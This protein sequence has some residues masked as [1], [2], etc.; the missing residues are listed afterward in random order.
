MV[1]TNS[2]IL[3]EESRIRQKAK[4]SNSFIREIIDEFID[5]E[6][7]NLIGLLSFEKERLN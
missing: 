6:I 4:T 1:I 2:I 3:L 5:D 7:E